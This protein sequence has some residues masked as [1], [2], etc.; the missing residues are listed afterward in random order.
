MKNN[1]SIVHIGFL[2]VLA[3]VLM[4]NRGGSPGGRTGSDTDGSGTCGTLGGCHSSSNSVILQDFLSS[5]IPETGYEPEKTYTIS[6]SPSKSNTSVWGFEMMAEDATGNEIGQFSNSDD[7]NLVSG[8]NRV[9]HK[10][11]HT[12]GSDAITWEVTWTAPAVGSG[13]V[14]FFGASLAANGNGKTSGDN[15]MVDTLMVKEGGVNALSNIKDVDLIIY[16]NPSTDRV[17][18]SGNIAPN[19]NVY[20]FSNK[21]DLVYQSTYTDQVSVRDLMSG[22]YYLKIVEGK[23]SVTKSFVKL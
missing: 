19:A 12:T 18:L 8:K 20:I 17:Y 5:D 22:T 13:E 4:S 10:F 15:V 23:E 6:V 3:C 21:G 11:A 14:T 16:P 1:F 9:T 2:A 7:A